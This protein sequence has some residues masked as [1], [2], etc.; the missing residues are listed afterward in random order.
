M[1]HMV[2]GVWIGR[3]GDVTMEYEVLEMSYML[4]WRVREFGC[5]VVEA[6]V[7]SDIHTK[8]TISKLFS[9]QESNWDFYGKLRA[10]EVLGSYFLALKWPLRL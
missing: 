6:G 7:E 4:R 1:I 5:V 9:A 10:D 3:S 8:I 2:V